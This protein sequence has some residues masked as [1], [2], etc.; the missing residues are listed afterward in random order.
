MQH[1]L[2]AAPAGVEGVLVR[3]THGNS[4]E[5]RAVFLPRGVFAVRCFCRAELS[6]PPPPPGPP[7]PVLVRARACASACAGESVPLSVCTRLCVLACLL[8][9]LFCVFVSVFVCL[10]VCVCVCVCARARAIRHLLGRGVDAQHAAG[11]EGGEV[12]DGAAVGPRR[13]GRVVAAQ[14]ALVQ[15]R[16]QALR[17]FIIIIIILLG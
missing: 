1:S 8:A 11:A 17:G 7:R 9:C 4:R 2:P 15:P 12:E 14:P 5:Q 6:P 13:R 10:C 3:C 16:Q